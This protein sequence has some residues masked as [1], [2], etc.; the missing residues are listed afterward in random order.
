MTDRKI[1][2]MTFE[3]F[4]QAFLKWSE[5]IIE[6]K[7]FDGF[8]I[9]PYARHARLN[10][11]VQFIDARENVSDLNKFDKEK[12][13]IGVAWLGDNNESLVTTEKYCEYLSELHPGL[14]YFTSTPQSGYFA[15]N[16]TNCVFIQLKDD[17]L[18]KRG[19]LHNTKYYES[20]PAEYYKAIT[21]QDK[22]S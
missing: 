12:Y 16:F 7:K 19:Q 13:E 6:A 8:P 20:W 9:C 10:N 17:I 3:E 5:E 11:L 18:E 2:P 4:C 1:I 21:G 14:L 15:K 22:L